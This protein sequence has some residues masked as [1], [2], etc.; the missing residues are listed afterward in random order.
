MTSSKQFVGSY[1][2]LIVGAGTA[3]CVLAHRLSAKG[4]TVLLIEAGMD[5]PPGSVP[6]DIEDIYPRSY[7]NHSYMWPGLRAEQR[8]RSSGHNQ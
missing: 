2:Y 6:T 4:A 7:Y 1:D 5:T 3:G 8:G